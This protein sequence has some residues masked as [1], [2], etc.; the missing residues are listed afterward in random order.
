VPRGECGEVRHRLRQHLMESFDRQ[1]AHQYQEFLRLRVERG[2]AEARRDPE[3]HD[4]ERE[5]QEKRGGVGQGVS[6]TFDDPEEAIRHRRGRAAGVHGGGS[7]RQS[8]TSPDS[9]KSSFYPWISGAYHGRVPGSSMRPKGVR[10]PAETRR[11]ADVFGAGYL[12]IVGVGWI[13]LS[14][15]SEIDPVTRHRVVLQV[16]VLLSVAFAL[17]LAGIESRTFGH[18]ES[19]VPGVDVP[20]WVSQ[21]P[22][23]SSRWTPSSRRAPGGRT[24]P[25]LLHSSSRA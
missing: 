2:D 23:R 10:G 22:P 21:P 25:A 19:F 24:S 6:G 16:L 13:P 7:F 11:S 18:P 8:G 12:P 17:R 1:E 4:G 5:D 3:H 15:G 9:P 14:N 20:E